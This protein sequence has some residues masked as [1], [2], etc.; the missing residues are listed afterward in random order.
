MDW[1]SAS[2]ALGSARTKQ[3]G[4]HLI[5]WSPL[6]QGPIHG[7][8]I[9]GEGN[10]KLLG[11]GESYTCNYTSSE[12]NYSIC[13]PCEGR[14]T[15]VVVAELWTSLPVMLSYF[16]HHSVFADISM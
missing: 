1:S 13:S 12:L 7:A 6:P 9:E 14:E 11:W 10:V 8:R 16:H 3:R 4:K 5:Q 15:T 2:E